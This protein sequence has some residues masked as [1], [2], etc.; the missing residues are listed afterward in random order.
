MRF[1]TVAEVRLVAA[2][3]LGLAPD[4]IRLVLPR[5]GRELNNQKR[6]CDYGICS[7][8]CIQVKLQSRLLGGGKP[9]DPQPEGVGISQ[10]V[11]GAEAQTTVNQ[12]E[13]SVPRS[14]WPAAL[15]ER[16]SHIEHTEERAIT[17]KQLTTLYEFMQQV[18]CVLCVLICP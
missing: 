2:L 13:G 10:P 3:Q 5:E 16:S 4:E 11:Q 6:L 14:E 15:L 9:H 18:L 12:W 17:L 1:S 7:T 8:D